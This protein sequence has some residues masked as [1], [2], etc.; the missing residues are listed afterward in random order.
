MLLY[1]QRTVTIII[2]FITTATKL[3][4]LV[5]TFRIQSTFYYYEYIYYKYHNTN[6]V[7]VP[8][9]AY[10]NS[11]TICHT[12]YQRLVFLRKM[13]ESCRLRLFNDTSKASK[14]VRV[15][16]R[17][18]IY[19]DERR[20]SY[21]KKKGTRKATKFIHTECHRL[22]QSHDCPLGLKAGRTFPLSNWLC[23]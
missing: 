4:N 3:H 23:W 7:S 2:R 22:L 12:C 13:F 15:L 16:C 14:L 20:R 1:W 17:W 18:R 5:Y 19:E 6:S 10:Y 11:T 8:L 9:F 21:K